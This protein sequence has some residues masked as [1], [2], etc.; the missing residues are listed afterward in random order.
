MIK[1]FALFSFIC[2]TMS[3][4]VD[5]YV[6]SQYPTLKDALAG[7]NQDGDRI[8]ITADQILS[9]EY[10]GIFKNV[11]IEGDA[12]NRG[13]ILYV[14]T[15]IVP[16]GKVT[17]H[18][19]TFYS[20]KDFLISGSNTSNFTLQYCNLYLNGHAGLY[21]TFRD[22]YFYN[23][24]FYDN[25]ILDFSWIMG[26]NRIRQC[27]FY[28]GI[29]EQIYVRTNETPPVDAK[30]SLQMCNFEMASDDRI[31]VLDNQSY[32]KKFTI[33]INSVKFNA[34]K[35]CSWP[36]EAFN[37]YPTSPMSLWVGFS[38]FNN[39]AESAWFADPSKIN[40]TLYSATFNNCRRP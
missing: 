35:N 4:A 10:T 11:W 31:L 34:T 17:F 33:E 9:G 1:F 30:L 25:G 6:P 40:V 38:V 16:V 19:L 2:I 12:A 26:D 21:G 24:N 18:N 22:F 29:G 13:R 37:F 15:T 28:R 20:L 14:N 39:C 5:R 7:C 27:N 3:W 36:I 23:D 32:L 8:I